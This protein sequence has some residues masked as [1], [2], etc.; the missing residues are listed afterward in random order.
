[1][2]LQLNS[3]QTEHGADSV[4]VMKKAVIPSVILQWVSGEYPNKKVENWVKFWKSRTKSKIACKKDLAMFKKQRILTSGVNGRSNRK[5]YTILSELKN[6]SQVN[7]S[8]H[9]GKSVTIMN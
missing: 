9:S 2:K 4:Y 6:T 3:N 8:W 7:S 1:M 5:G